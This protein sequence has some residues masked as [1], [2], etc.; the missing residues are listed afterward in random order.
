M[1]LPWN[2]RNG[3]NAGHLH[4]LV[5]M[6]ACV[7]SLLSLRYSHAAARKWNSCPSI[8]VSPKFGNS[9]LALHQY[10]GQPRLYHLTMRLC[11][12]GPKA[13]Y[14]RSR[15]TPQ[16]GVLRS[17]FARSDCT[18]RHS[19]NAVREPPRSSYRTR[20]PLPSALRLD[21]GHIQD[22]RYRTWSYLI[23]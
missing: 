2:L 7:S 3:T 1:N 12:N 5:P 15:L 14:G 6:S 18:I 22:G 21:L 20:S 11:F 17:F 10:Q 19:S 8:D 16:C 13:Q 4:L 23:D 9:S